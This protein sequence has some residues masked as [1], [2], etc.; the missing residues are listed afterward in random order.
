[1]QDIILWGRKVKKG[2]IMSGH[3]YYYD[4]DTS[5]R[6]AKVTQAINDY[7]AIHGIKFYITDEKHALLMGDIY[8]SW[9]WLKL[10][11]I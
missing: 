2:G 11:D 7:T 4:Q 8:P 1:M 9:F 10:E 5:R 3:D 6:R